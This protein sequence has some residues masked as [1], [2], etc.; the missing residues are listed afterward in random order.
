MRRRRSRWTS[1]SSPDTTGQSG[2]AIGD[3]VDVKVNYGTVEDLIAGENVVDDGISDDGG[4]VATLTSESLTGPLF[5]SGSELLG[6]V[7]LTDLERNEQVI[8][9][10]DVKLFCDPG[11]NPTGNLQG[12]LDA[13]TLTFIDDTAPVVPAQALPGGAQTV[14][15]KQIGNIAVPDIDVVKTVT[16]D[17]GTC[18]GVDILTVTSGDTV[19]YCYVVSNTGEAPLYNVA[20]V[21]DNGTPADAADDFPITLT[22]LTDVDLDGNADDL[23]VGGSASG[24]APVTLTTSGSVVNTATASGDDAIIQPTTLTA[25]D[26]AEVLVNDPDFGTIVIVK[27]AVGGPETFDFTGDWGEVLPDG[28]FQIT[29]AGAGAATN[30]SVTY[31]EVLP[32][33]YSVAEVLPASPWSL[34]SVTCEDGDLQGGLSGPGAIELDPGETVICTF[35]NTR[36]SATLTVDKTWVNAVVGD[37]VEI[38]VDGINDD[39]GSSVADTP[40]ETDADVAGTTVFVGE[41]IALDETFTTGNAGELHLDPVVRLRPEQRSDRRRC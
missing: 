21:D 25:T 2:V 7:Q 11:S 13:A 22:G 9:R 15:F 16:T 18:P 1:R 6:T 30:G 40:N 17:T 8:V 27:N 20:L 12:Q 37:A 26:I 28:D 19:T 39:T 10:I 32:G 14:P 23:A 41:T 29:T 4:S 24:Q 33:S 35:T 34:T 3:I 31:T 5:D 38:A 36:D